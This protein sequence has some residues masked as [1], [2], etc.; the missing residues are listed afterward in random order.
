MQTWTP[1]Q[2]SAV[3]VVAVAILTAL[4]V[5]SAVINIYQFWLNHRPS[6]TLKFSDAY[7][8]TLIWK[9]KGATDEIDS[10]TQIVIQ[11]VISIK[12]SIKNNSSRDTTIIAFQY[13]IPQRRLIWYDTTEYQIYGIR[14]APFVLDDEILRPS[15]PAGRSPLISGSFLVKS[16]WI[17]LLPRS[18]RTG[19]HESAYLQYRVIGPPLDPNVRY[20]VKVT[21]EDSFKSRTTNIC[22]SFKEIESPYFSSGAASKSSA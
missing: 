13:E 10:L 19:D 11:S 1:D 12:L 22:L 16:S 5:V 18:L 4:L 8:S 17:H 3:A 14:N 15:A 2:I 6:L 9:N 20:S 7:F 21:V